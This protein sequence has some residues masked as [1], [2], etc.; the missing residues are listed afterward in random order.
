MRKKKV[1]YSPGWVDVGTA[2]EERW[3]GRKGRPCEQRLRPCNLGSEYK[4]ESDV[5]EEKK[6]KKQN[7]SRSK[8]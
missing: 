3:T 8:P 4:G 5:S 1:C 6:Q 2:G 7:G